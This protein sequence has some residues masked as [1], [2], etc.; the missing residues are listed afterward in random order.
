[1]T[2]GPRLALGTVQF[3][4]AYGIAG[5]GTV[6]DPDE[7]RSILRLAADHGVDRL[8]TAPAYGSIED[9]LASLVRDLPFSVVSKIPSLTA[10]STPD[11]I[12]QVQLSIDTSSQR[13]GKSLVGLL[14]HDIAALSGPD[15]AEIWS[16]AADEC[17]ARGLMLGVSSYDP[18]D[19]ANLCEDFPLEMTQLPGN[20]FDQRV[21]AARERL[22]GIEVTLRSLLL[23]GLLLMHDEA[24]RERLPR[25]TDAVRRWSDWCLRNEVSRLEGV[26]AVARS[27]PVQYCV[28]GVESAAQLREILAAWRTSPRPAPEL[29]MDDMAIIDPRRWP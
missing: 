11:R 27:F 12:R 24:V 6:V 2:G 5:R 20:P 3:G 1:M 7:V 22:S 25:A 4:L 8:D 21:R 18:A 13:L 28:I 9:R 19:V 17:R 23:Q 26:A 29:A 10:S 16:V 14:F 15:A